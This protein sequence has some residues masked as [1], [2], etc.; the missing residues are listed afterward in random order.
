MAAYNYPVGVSSTYRDNA[1]QDSIYEQG[2][3]KAGQIVTNARGGQSMHNYRL[4][5]DIYKNIKGQEYSDARFFD[6]AGKIWQEMGGT[7]GGSWA[8]FPDK[9]HFEFTGGLSI[10]DLQ[11]GKILPEQAKMPWETAQIVSTKGEVMR[12]NTVEEVPDWA[13]DTVKHLLSK[14]YLKGDGVGLD[15][16]LDMLRLLVISD[17][18][19]M[20]GA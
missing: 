9:P 18:A 20:F 6:L 5:F 12:F 15:L 2:R 16:S 17:R 3:S 8:S 10:S 14:G 11:K 7:W 1:Y 13:R 19:G 4:A